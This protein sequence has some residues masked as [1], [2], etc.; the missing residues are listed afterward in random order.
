M[1]T[2]FLLTMEKVHY[3]IAKQQEFGDPM[4]TLKTLGAAL[5]ALPFACMAVQPA[6]ACTSPQQRVDEQ[7]FVRINGIEQWITM[8]GDSCANPVLLIAHGGPGN[9]QS[10][11]ANGPDAGWRKDFTVVHWDQRGAGMTYGRNKPGEDEQL[12]VE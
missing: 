2:R 9:P 8:Q 5:L 7:G 12:T 10:L 3:M 6:P 1:H 11:Y 4:N